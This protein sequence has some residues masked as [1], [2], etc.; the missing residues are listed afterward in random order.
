[1]N[2]DLLTVHCVEA[3]NSSRFEI[4]WRCYADNLRLAFAMPVKKPDMNYV[5]FNRVTAKVENRHDK[6]NSC[7]I[8]ALN[9]YLCQSIID[10]TYIR[11]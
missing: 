8:S 5:A 4:K 3:R 7:V 9:L 2:C 1:M 11:V 6:I 10:K